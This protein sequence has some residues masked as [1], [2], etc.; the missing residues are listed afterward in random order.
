MPCFFIA[1][2]RRGFT[3]VE[4]MV[5]MFLS[6]IVSYAVYRSYVAYCVSLDTHDQTLEMQQNLR[7]SMNDMIHDIRM[8]GYDPLNSS[9]AGFLTANATEIE[10]NMDLAE[11]GDPAT[12]TTVKYEFDN[13]NDEVDQDSI[14]LI[15]NVSHLSFVYLDTDR[16]VLAT[17]VA[18]LADIR[19]VQICLVV[20]TGKEDF[21]YTDTRVYQ[22]LQGNTVFPLPPPAPPPPPENAHFHRRVLNVEVKCRNMGL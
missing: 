22:N 13:S 21:S 18:S 19:T 20:Q 6:T 16:T 7:I 4:L 5:A 3:L 12:D 2:H 17:P 9:G 14:S 10:F 1:K 8:A 15:Q 11:D